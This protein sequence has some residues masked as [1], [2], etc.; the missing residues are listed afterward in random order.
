MPEGD[1]VEVDQEGGVGGMDG[2]L[3]EMSARPNQRSVHVALGFRPTSCASPPR[4]TWSG[5]RQ[6]RGSTRGREPV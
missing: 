4:R 6:D 3:A 5:M 1:V 2:G